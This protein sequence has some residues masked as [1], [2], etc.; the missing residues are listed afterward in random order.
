MAHLQA[1]VTFRA[2]VSST[3]KLEQI[4][5][6]SVSAP[7][8]SGGVKKALE[9]WLFEP[10]TSANKIECEYDLK[11]SFKLLPGECGPT[12]HCPSE[13]EFHL[14]NEVIVRAKPLSGNGP[15][16]TGPPSIPHLNRK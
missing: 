13:L 5:V 9:Q 15:D 1:D 12:E 6:T 14:P 16:W 7:I 10:C 11:V 4:E 2:F 8:L 3:G